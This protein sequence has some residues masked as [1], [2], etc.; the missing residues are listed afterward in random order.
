VP[1]PP[2]FADI[3]IQL[4]NIATSRPAYITF[5]VDPSDTDPALVGAAVSA[6]ASAPGSLMS[7]MDTN[8][9]MSQIR[10]SMG[11]DGLEDIVYLHPASA[12]GA[13]AVSSFPPNCAVLVHKT[14]ARGG[15]RGRG[16]FFVPWM[17]GAADC[18]EGGIIQTSTLTALQGVFTSF[19]TNLATGGNPMFVM[20]DPSTTGTLHPT[21]AG[22][23]NAVLSL[24]VDKLVSTQR[25]RL[26][27]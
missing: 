4:Q 6:A 24:V 15:R 8:V 12:V 21:V 9:T 19:R 3:S 26:G 22:P 11:T 1:T 27:R 5:G 7:K 25:R 16:R 14:T 20:H 10:V 13:N 2:G 17:L 23:P 18:N